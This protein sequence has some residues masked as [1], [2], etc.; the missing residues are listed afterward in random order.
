MV[1]SVLR[2]RCALIRVR[3]SCAG[4]LGR[5][6]RTQ[7]PD[8]GWKAHVA[9][10]R[11]RAST[12]SIASLSISNDGSSN[13]KSV[14]ASARLPGRRLQSPISN[15]RDRLLDPC[16]GW[17]T[18][19][20]RKAVGCFDRTREMPASVTP[21]ASAVG[22]KSE[23]AGNPGLQACAK[24][25]QSWNVDDNKQLPFFEPP[26]S[27]NVYGNKQ[28]IRESWNLVDVQVDSLYRRIRFL[29]MSFKTGMLA[30]NTPVCY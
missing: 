16:Q 4:S 8:T 3:T 24:I 2:P 6:D 11:G 13:S 21:T 12:G 29:I 27:W 23:K 7:P 18:Q 15:L 30:Y 20:Q 14:P 9:W 1:K 5:Q 26:E 17:V 19:R 28:V 25:K 10:R 22:E